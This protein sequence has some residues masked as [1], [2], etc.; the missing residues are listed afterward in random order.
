[1]LLI[2]I[3]HSSLLYLGG[4]ILERKKNKEK[5]PNVIL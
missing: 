5:K 4:L 3:S 2:L 1:M